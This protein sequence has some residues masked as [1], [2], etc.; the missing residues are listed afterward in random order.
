MLKVLI[1]EDEVLIAQHIKEVLI[2]SN[3]SVLG[4]AHDS[5]SALDCIHSRQPELIILNIN[6]DG[7]KDGIEVAEI[8]KEKYDIPIVFLTALS[9]IKTLERAKK[10][11][12]A[13]YIVKPFKAKD[14]V[15]S[16]VIGMYN[17]DF[18]K[19]SK[20][21]SIEKVN[22]ITIQPISSKEYEVLLD[23]QDGLTN[24]QI[25]K[26]QF[27]SLSTIK[28]HCKNIYDKLEVKNRTSAIRKVYA[29]DDNPS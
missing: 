10:V 1:V 20:A 17:Y 24:A 26:K 5:E 2:Q 25:A 12:P 16:I 29:I 21:M 23:I 14:L 11:N 22:T 4:I 7:Y 13:A 27:L 28:F 19:K 18:R 15:S 9:D 8:V 6:I 3:Y